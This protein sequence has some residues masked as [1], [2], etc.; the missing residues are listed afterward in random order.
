MP[1]MNTCKT[2]RARRRGVGFRI[3]I[4]A[5]SLCAIEG[6]LRL[7][8]H[9]GLM[10]VRVH[11]TAGRSE[12]IRFLGDLDPHF[13]AWHMPDATVSV[14]T[15]NGEV[16]YVSNA[17]GMRDRPR[18]L[19]STALERVAVL[20]DSF[21]EGVGVEAAD[22]VADILEERTGIEFLNFG[23]AGGFG[24]VQEWLLY[25]HMASH[26]DHSRVFLFCLPD[27]DFADNRAPRTSTTR[28]R[29]YLQPEGDTYRVVY[30]FPFD[31][32]QER[33]RD[34]PWG[35]RFRNQ[36]LNH[37]CTANVL[38]DLQFREIRK[39]L[40]LSSS[41]DVYSA[42]DLKKLLYT[43]E[44]ILNLARPRPLTLFVIPRDADFKAQAAGRHQ[45]RIVADLVA[46][47]AQHEGIRI[48]DL[49]PGF[50]AHMKE[51]GVSHRAF[52]LE[53]DPHWSPLGHAVAAD[54]VLASHRDLRPAVSC[55]QTRL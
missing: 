9:R 44:Q 15:A 55:R 53:H 23:T 34:L 19:K 2:L 43:Y 11:P 29:P 35:R 51:H 38:N 37:W 18:S 6:V 10:R 13:G 49:M 5:L 21:V 24:S 42:G 33:Q 32:L 17:H 16:R 7:A 28:Y 1:V 3:A 45:G 8:A 12:P 14:A 39:S 41:Y 4:V 31:R 48:V 46:F 25:R 20:G 52:F 26:Y 47:A 22:R 36:V 30:P 54:I 40:R 27:N 50:L